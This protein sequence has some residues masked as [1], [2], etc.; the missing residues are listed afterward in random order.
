MPIPER[1]KRLDEELDDFD[2]DYFNHEIHFED[3][4]SLIR[5]LLDMEVGQ[6]GRNLNEDT[7]KII[8]MAR[9]YL[10]KPPVIFLDEEA[11]FIIGIN[12]NF[13]LKQMF[14]NLREAGILSLSKDLRQLHQYSNVCILKDSK[15]IEQGPPLDLIDN[16]KSN[17]YNIVMQDDI[18][19]LRQLEHKLEKNI[20]K[21]ENMQSKQRKRRIN[22][23]RDP[24]ERS[25][26]QVDS[27]SVTPQ[28][29]DS[30]YQKT[31]SNL[32]GS[33]NGTNLSRMNP[34]KFTMLPMLGSHNDDDEDEDDMNE[35][36][37][38]QDD[39]NRSGSQITHKELKPQNSKG[40]SPTGSNYLQAPGAGTPFMT[41]GPLT[42]ST[43][44]FD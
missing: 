25:V 42:K 3:E 36:E 20:R 41:S 8:K 12:R 15:I 6:N 23:E 16:K 14:I 39:L 4:K 26:V 18:R 22:V 28:R 34:K 35:E 38:K 5:N 44:Q 13:Y 37:D 7:R 27:E 30:S 11:C 24:N 31:P 33:Q 9:V 2:T 21:F 29:M 19:T 32:P 40:H 1:A 43:P 17:M 10:E